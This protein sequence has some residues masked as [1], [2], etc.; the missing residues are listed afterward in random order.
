MRL[1]LRTLLAYMDDRLPPEKAREI[2]I[3]IAQ[4]PFAG[5]L[6]ERIRDVKRRRRI[7]TAAADKPGVDANLVAEY[8]DDQLSADLV[9]RIEQKI[10]A[11]DP[12]LAEVASAHELLG[13]LRDPIELEPGLKDRLYALDPTGVTDVVRASGRSTSPESASASV[14]WQPENARSAQSRHW[15]AVTIAGLTII[16]LLSLATDSSLLRGPADLSGPSAETVQPGEV[17]VVAAEKVEPPAAAIPAESEVPAA[18][19]SPSDPTTATDSPTQPAPEPAVAERPIQPPAPAA[20]PPAMAPDAPAGDADLA[21]PAAPRNLLLQAENRIVLVADEQRG[22]WTNLLQIRG[23]DAVVPAL[24]AVNC[25]PLLGKNWFGIPATFEMGIRSTGQVWKAVTSGG[26]LFRIPEGSSDLQILSGQLILTTD[27][28]QAWPEGQP[29]ALSLQTGTEQVSITL[30]SDQTRVAVEVRPAATP[31]VPTADNNADAVENQQPAERASFLL[32]LDSDLTVRLTLLEGSAVVGFS[33]ANE[34]LRLESS[35]TLSWLIVEGGERSQLERGTLAPAAIPAWMLRS[36]SKP[37]PEVQAVQDRVLDVLS[38]AGIPGELVQPLLTDRN[39]QVGLAAAEVLC[40]MAD[41]NL[42]LTAL[43]E[44]L[45]ESV[46]RRI[47]EGLRGA[48]TASAAGRASVAASLETRLSM[49]DAAFA[50]QMIGGLNETEA[51]DRL[52]TGRLLQYL[53]GDSL[54]LRTLA[55][56]EMERLTGGRQNYFPN[57][58]ASRRRDAVNRWQRAIERNGGTLLP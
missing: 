47:I 57:A 35:E 22:Q 8:L 9:Q 43:F 51:R 20:E 19:D 6:L 55:I 58:E 27:E 2:G 52:I 25:R 36:E 30:L 5:E 13:L 40:L 48:V 31:Q 50:L 10:L 16:W 4:S 11:S 29:P 53:Q 21:L 12:L 54:T 28:A 56:Y 49:A 38:A 26:G 41:T 14:P 33:D 34:P 1:T 45:D 32:P 37:I 17:A 46:H 23:G 44:V 39:P 7:A 24:N 42:L 15:P 18:A 3:K